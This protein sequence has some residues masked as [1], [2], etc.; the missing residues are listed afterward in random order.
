MT[1]YKILTCEECA[2]A[3]LKAENPTILI[4]V[5]PDADAIGSAAALF[6][7]FKH[8]GK[9]SKITCEHDVPER[10]E[11]ILDY[12]GAIFDKNAKSDCAIAIDVASRAQ[13]GTLADRFPTVSLMID[14]H[15]KGTPFADCYA[16]PDM[17]SAG[18]VLYGVAEVLIKRGLISLDEKLAYALYSSISSDTGRFCYKSA[19]PKTYRTA[20]TL[21]ECGIDWADINHKLFFSKSEKQIK[22]EG[23]VSSK[24]V[25]EGSISYATITI[26]ERDALLL[27]EEHFE[28]A[29]EVVRS[30]RGTEV[31]FF[32]REVADGKFKASL[33]STTKNVAKV[34][35]IFGGGGHILAAGCTLSA[36][37]AE[38]AASLLLSEL[39]KN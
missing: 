23:L 14:H 37:T 3:L 39:K 21:M 11:F 2:D 33:R 18:E 36:S 4:H 28:T 6:L 15:A 26:A 16:I 22:A 35:E 38:E 24:I 25:T 5:R 32:I 19:S 29:I 1:D 13:L 34:A 20:A 27:L 31:S 8:L 7:I 9:A 12:T 30:V 10:L 17:S